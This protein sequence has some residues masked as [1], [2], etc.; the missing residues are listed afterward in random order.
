LS[1]SNEKTG[2]NICTIKFIKSFKNV[3]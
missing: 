2:N 3:K 1:N